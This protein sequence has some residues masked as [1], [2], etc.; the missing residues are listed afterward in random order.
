[1]PPGPSPNL[2][3]RRQANGA[4]LSLLGLASCGPVRSPRI[5]LGGGGDATLTPAESRINLVPGRPLFTPVRVDGP[6]PGS[7]TPLLS[8]P[9]NRTI[10]GRLVWIGLQPETARGSSW[11]PSVDRWV[12]TPVSEGVVPASVGAWHVIADLPADAVGQPIRLGEQTLP[13]NWLADPDAIKPRGLQGGWEPWLAPGPAPD[14]S[15]LTPEWQSPLRRWRARLATGSLGGDPPANT[16]WPVDGDAAV[17]DQLAGLIEARWRVGLARLWYADPGASREVA[18]RLTRTIELAPGVRAPAWPVGQ[19]L[20][21]SLL[22]DLLDPNLTGE[23]LTSRAR[24]WLASLPATVAWVD[25]DAAGLLGS[26]GEPLAQFRAARLADTPAMLWLAG[27]DGRRVGEP[28]AIEPTQV[29]ALAAP[30][31]EGQPAVNSAGFTLRAGGES[32]AIPARAALDIRPPGV[33]CTPLMR[34]WTLEAWAASRPVIGGA[35]DPGWATAVLVYREESAG[36][37]PR[38]AAYVE[39]SAAGEG[40]EEVALHF[41]Q[42]GSPAAV[43]RLTRAGVLRADRNPEDELRVD[44]A[45]TATSWSAVVPIPAE[46]IEP[47]NI[48]RLG[49]TRR[50]ARGVRTAWPRRMM[51]WDR[52]PSRAAI[53]LNAWSGLSGP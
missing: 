25:D 48:L 43:L 23:P 4:I 52:E 30:V 34:D 21:D 12:V 10:A 8:L 7:A 6:L 16:P 47:A 27:R 5:A 38:W 11:L 41:G 32:I 33:N 53:R 1:M 26:D 9:G 36:G 46:A 51:P 29:T 20:L 50:D 2:I 14:A 45:R 49:I 15:L 17:L 3:S 18:T 19:P 31:G 40:A 28:M 44:I 39:C 22:A 37:A 35:P 13:I 24:G 42:R